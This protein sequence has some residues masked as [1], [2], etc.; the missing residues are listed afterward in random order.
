[1]EKLLPQGQEKPSREK[2]RVGEEGGEKGNQH[3]R[4]EFSCQTSAEEKNGSGVNKTNGKYEGGSNCW[5]IT[6]RTWRRENN[7]PKS[8]KKGQKHQ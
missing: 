3:G 2:K 8:K 1:V 5:G 6:I 4:K 7:Q